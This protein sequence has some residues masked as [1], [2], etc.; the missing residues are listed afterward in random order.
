M[1]VVRSTLARRELLQA[2]RRVRRERPEAQVIAV[3]RD[4]PKVFLRIA[5]GYGVSFCAPRDLLE[6]RLPSLVRL[7]NRDHCE[8]V[9]K[10]RVGGPRPRYWRTGN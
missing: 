6:V 4:E 1:I 5:R 7:A 8:T 3:T 9:E 2:V 10:L